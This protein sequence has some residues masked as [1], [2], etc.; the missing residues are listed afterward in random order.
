MPFS[1][2]RS[3]MRCA[4]AFLNS[5]DVLTVIKNIIEFREYL[6]NMS[7]YRHNIDVI[8][9]YNAIGERI[10]YIRKRN[11]YTQEQLALEC[12]LSV[13]YI[14]Q[15]ENG[16][17][18]VSLN[19]LLQIADALECTLD[20]LVFG[21]EEAKEENGLEHILDN[22]SLEDRRMLSEMLNMSICFLEN[23]GKTDVVS[24]TT[25]R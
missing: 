15:V 22:Y 12:D 16:R 4:V 18:S 9:D 7:I 23:R 19:A 3:F 20:S 10:R 11:G 8:I 13:P 25:K 5:M 1:L 14:S 6:E 21:E 17:K 2:Q 24:Q